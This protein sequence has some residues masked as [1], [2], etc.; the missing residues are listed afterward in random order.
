MEFMRGCVTPTGR[1]LVVLEYLMAAGP[2]PVKQVDIAR[3]C[4]LSTA[5]L[6]RIIQELSDWGY[7]FRTSERYCI[8]NFRMTRNVP[9]SMRYLAELENTVTSLTAKLGAAAEVTVVA[10]HELLWHLISHH[11]DPRVT[12]RAQVGFRRSLY[13]LDALS[14]MYL[15]QLPPDELTSRF[16]TEGFYRTGHKTD[17][18][19]EARALEIIGTDRNQ[20][21]ISDDQPNHVGIQRYAT[22]VQ[23]PD[24]EFLH[25]LSIA[26]GG[27]LNG[28]GDSRR[29]S[30]QDAL[31]DAR[32]RLGQL[33][34]DEDASNRPPPMHHVVP[35]MGG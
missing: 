11:P 8:R 24:G 23:S 12:I 35:Q 33:I 34:E 3:A 1:T 4:N 9:V 32:Q 30:Y 15:S 25:L 13:E 31:E 26:D 19:P 17:W 22:V 28:A 14:R 29:A 7:L 2:G 27:A 5:T 16:Y 6:N 21:F 20:T 18:I 10:G